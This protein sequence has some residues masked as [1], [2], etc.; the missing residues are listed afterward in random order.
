MTTKAK[1]IQ[2][3]KVWIVIYPS[4]TLFNVLFGNYLTNLPLSMKT[5]TLTLVLVPWMVFV[6]LPVV[7]MIHQ[8]IS[9]K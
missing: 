8:K 5:L 6:G 9:K 2:A 7:N 1:I 3:I 4:I